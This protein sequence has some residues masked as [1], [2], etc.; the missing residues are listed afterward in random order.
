MT[1]A[2]TSWVTEIQVCPSILAADFGAFR[3]QVRDLL[4]AGAR[5]FHVDVMDGHFVPVITFGH[6]VVSALADDVH[7]RGGA[8]AVH[9]MVERPER[10][11]DDFARAGADSFTIHVEATV[12]LRYWLEQIRAA[13]M[14]PGVT[15]NPGTPVGALEEAARYAENLLCMSVDPGWGGQPFI[16]ATLDRLPRLRAMARAGAGVEVDG[17][18]GPDT[19]AACFAGGANRLTAG[20]AI[21]AAA[22][23]GQAYR[24]LVDLVGA[25][26]T[27]AWMA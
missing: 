16:P 26:G 24:D 2:E 18:V 12:H 20:S 14:V 21:F 4:D 1:S 7:G 8:L 3:S 10:F 9:L 6:Q 22:D 5:T 11:I 17:G 25:V 15:L 13:G 19:I 27:P 23:P